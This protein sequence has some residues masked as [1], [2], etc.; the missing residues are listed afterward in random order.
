MEGACSSSRREL[1]PAKD[2][3]DEFAPSGRKD[4]FPLSDLQIVLPII[5]GAG[6][7]GL[8]KREYQNVPRSKAS[9][10]TGR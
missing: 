3:A 9:K 1:Q 5:E 8:R 7:A 10:P 6:Q 4:I 2:K